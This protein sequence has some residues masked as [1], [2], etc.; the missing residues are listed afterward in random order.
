MQDR[1]AALVAAELLTAD[2]L[3]SIDDLV[4]DFVAG[5]SER[6]RWTGAQAVANIVEPSE[7]FADD[8]RLVRQLRRRVL[9]LL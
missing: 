4:A 8:A 1:I 6:E 5:A 2:E 9:Q 3:D 7:A